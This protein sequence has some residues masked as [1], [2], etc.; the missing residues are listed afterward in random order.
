MIIEISSDAE[1]DIGHGYWFYESQSLGVG[2][3][4]RSSVFAD[5]DSLV[6]HAGSHVVVDGYYRKVCS[7][8]PYNIYYEMNSPTSLVI[9]AVIGQRENRKPK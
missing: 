2:D 6:I 9:V 1:K 7:T 5:I 4:F 3:Y 8:F